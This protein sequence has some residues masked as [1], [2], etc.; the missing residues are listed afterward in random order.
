[1]VTS[2]DVTQA[3]IQ[4]RSCLD[5]DSGP[6]MAAWSY[7]ISP[8]ASRCLWLHPSPSGRPRLVAGSSRKKLEGL[9]L[10]RTLSIIP[11]IPFQ[12]WRAILT[13]ATLSG[14]AGSQEANTRE[15]GT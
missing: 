1:M 11:S 8:S 13:K 9:L 10:G 15:G 7:M 6:L 3:I 4:S 5:I 12:T 2:C 14:D